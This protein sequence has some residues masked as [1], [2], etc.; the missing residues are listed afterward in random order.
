MSCF[1][2]LKNRD[3]MSYIA[4]LIDKN[5]LYAFALTCKA[6][7]NAVLSLNEPI[8]TTY[9]SLASSVGLIEWAVNDGCPFE[10]TSFLNQAANDGNLPVV[11]WLCDTHKFVWNSCDAAEN[12][13]FNG[14]IHLLEWAFKDKENDLSGIYNC[15][16]LNGQIDVLKWGLENNITIG[17]ESDE[18]DISCVCNAAAEGGQK[19]T[20]D[21]LRKNN[22]K[23]DTFT[24]AGA[25]RGGHLELLQW[26][27]AE[28]CPWSPNVYVQAVKRG[29][30]EMIKWAFENGLPPLNSE[31]CL[32]AKQLGHMDIFEWAIDNGFLWMND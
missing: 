6:A 9:S 2:L 10:T 32:Y 31:L 24:T 5:A 25:A 16:A 26:L 11:E 12:A 13:A 15:A 8:E 20:L 1:D 28:G 30:F 23:W 29:N 3:E 27:R 4:S 22:F 7:Y 19:D 14:H 21:W 18:N 17:E